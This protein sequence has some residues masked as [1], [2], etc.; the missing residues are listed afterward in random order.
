M[1]IQDVTPIQIQQENIAQP[2]ESQQTQQSQEI[3]FA[4]FLG[5]LKNI[6]TIND[7]FLAC[8]FFIKNML[9]EES[10][11]MKYIN[12]KLFQTTGKIASTSSADELIANGYLNVINDNESKKYFITQIGE[13]YFFAT[14]QG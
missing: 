12:S 6:N 3:N 11:T 7:E 1:V 9:G 4:T 2:I 10:F 5:R 8:A 13:Q 14:Y